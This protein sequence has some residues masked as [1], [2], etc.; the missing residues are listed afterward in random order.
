MSDIS[1]NDGGGSKGS[2]GRRDTPS[3][4]NG[5]PSLAF[6]V[7]FNNHGQPINIQLMGRAWDDDKLVALAF[8]FEPTARINAP[9]AVPP[10]LSKVACIVAP[11]MGLL[12]F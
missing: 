10:R 3:A 7:G 11:Q 5:V 12:M 1:L 9:A 4:Q 6:P 8:A 2:F